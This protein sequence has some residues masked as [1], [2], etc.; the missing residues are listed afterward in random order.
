MVLPISVGVN[1]DFGTHFSWGI[2]CTFFDLGTI[3]PDHYLGDC[4]YNQ[5]F[6]YINLFVKG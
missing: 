3:S 1:F 2:D 5:K 4:P 6:S